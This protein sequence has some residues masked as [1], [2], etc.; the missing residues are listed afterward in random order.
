VCFPGERGY[1]GDSGRYL[2][3]VGWRKIRGG[4]ECA[5]L[6][7]GADGG[8]GSIECFQWPSDVEGGVVPEDGAL[9]DG[10]VKVGGFV[11][12]LGGIGEDE[13]AVG[14]AFGDPEELEVVIGGLGFEVETGPFAEVRRVAAEIDGDVPDMSGEDADKFPLGL[15]ELVVQ[16]T[17]DAFDGER[18]VVLNEL[19]GKAGS[20]KR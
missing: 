6:V 13:E 16:A 12:N 15:A 14:E 10:V 20:G 19:S 4:K 5:T 18:L 2:K 17:Q 9:S 3:L 1:Y 7:L 8:W 11:K